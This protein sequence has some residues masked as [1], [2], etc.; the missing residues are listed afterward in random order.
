MGFVPSVSEVM[1]ETSGNS[2]HPPRMESVET[3]SSGQAQRHS[4]PPLTDSPWFWAYL[5][6]VAALVALF[7]AGP[8]YQGRQPQLENQYKARQHGGQA[9]AGENGPIPPSSAERT[10]I[11]LR[12]LYLTVAA[13]LVV[14]WTGLWLQ[15]YR[16]PHMKQAGRDSAR[17]KE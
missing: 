11:T 4:R 16:S 13:L 10:I 5:F 2:G 3:S 1:T 14:A 7:A 12:P 9:V 8:R 6:S 17:I 15:R